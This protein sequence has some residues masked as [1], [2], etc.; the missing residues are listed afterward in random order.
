M[1][2]VS[3]RWWHDAPVSKL[4]TARVGLG[5]VRDGLDQNGLGRVD[6]LNG[7]DYHGSDLEVSL[8]SVLD[9]SGQTGR[10]GQIWRCHCD[11]Y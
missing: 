1:V 11:L 4:K 7:T 6:W 8:R 5:R 9:P 10:T 2:R 3:L